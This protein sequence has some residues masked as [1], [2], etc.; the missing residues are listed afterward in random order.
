[1]DA[2]PSNGRRAALRSED[3]I[4]RLVGRSNIVSKVRRQNPLFLLWVLACRLAMPKIACCTRWT[5]RQ[6][7]MHVGGWLRST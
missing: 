7:L 3:E 4:A 2:D 5:V 1:M 6:C